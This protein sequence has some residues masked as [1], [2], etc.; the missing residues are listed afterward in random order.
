MIIDYNED[1]NIQDII[2]DE[3]VVL[4]FWAPWCG[5]CKQLA[6]VLKKLSDE[7]PSLKICKINTDEFS[8]VSSEF[9][10]RALPT[11]MFYKNGECVDTK[12]GFINGTILE[13]KV[14]GIYG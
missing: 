2:T 1:M 10:I 14:K 5:P 9:S 3:N 11:L 6:P 7:N 8:D 4:D 13:E 12:V